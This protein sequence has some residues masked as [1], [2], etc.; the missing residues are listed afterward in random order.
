MDECAA[1][2]FKLFTQA[3]IEY[4]KSNIKKCKKTKYIEKKKNHA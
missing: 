3:K 2:C 4:K 1:N